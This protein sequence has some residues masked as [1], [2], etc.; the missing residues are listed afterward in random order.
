MVSKAIFRGVK[1]VVVRG[2]LIVA[3][4]T[5]AR[6]KGI[7]PAEDGYEMDA[8]AEVMDLGLGNRV[9]KALERSVANPSRC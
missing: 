3:A 8:M 1:L 7:L 2:V 5:R 6:E 4:C 9:G